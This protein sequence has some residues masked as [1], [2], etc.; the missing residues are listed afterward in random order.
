MKNLLKIL[1]VCLILSNTAFASDVFNH[2]AS[3]QS[4][5]KAIPDF[6]NVN[7]TF[8]QTKTIPNSPAVLKSGGD[9]TFDKNKGVVFY[10]KYPVKMTTAYTKNEQVNKIINDVV[11]KNYS[12][13]EKN[14][15]FYFLNNNVW[16][17]GLIPKNPQMKRYIK[18]LYIAGKTDIHTIEIKNVD[19]TVTRI[20]FKVS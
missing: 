6:K 9:F 20:N 15:N 18:S 12:S 3:V 13:L 10:T 1:L 16:E 7:C 5:I 8:T 17:L 19:G 11:N 14:F 4:I 2:P